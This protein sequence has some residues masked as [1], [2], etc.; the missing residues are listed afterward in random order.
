MIKPLSLFTLFC[1]IYG[2]TVYAQDAAQVKATKAAESAPKCTST[3]CG[4]TATG[5]DPSEVAEREGRKM[6]K[7][8]R[9]SAGDRQRWGITLLYSS[10]KNPDGPKLEI[11]KALGFS[12]H[13]Q[14]KTGR[15]TFEK[16]GIS[17]TF[18]IA[19]PPGGPNDLCPKYALAVV[20]A[21]AEH[22]IVKRSCFQYEYKPQRF[23][24]GVEFFLYDM[25]TASMRSI[26]NAATEDTTLSGALVTPNPTLKLI[27]DGYLLDWTVTDISKSATEKYRM[28]TKYVRV[29]PKNGKA[30]TLTCTDLSASKGEDV[31]QGAC[32]GAHP[33]L[34]SKQ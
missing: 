25:P 33:E 23:Y 24:K 31:E 22:A 10:D 9:E 8:L 4:N 19:G 1:G 7:E 17:Q 34:V 21:S 26:W 28:R 27:K 3:P 15:L 13:L 16:N 5:E 20:D 12:A 32:E 18:A 29:I 30:P 11:I 14:P 6:L 2:S